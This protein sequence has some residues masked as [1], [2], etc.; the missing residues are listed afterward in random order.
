MNTNENSQNTVPVED[1]K[2]M[3]ANWR[4]FLETNGQKFNVRSYSIPLD[5]YQNLLTNNPDLES[6]RVYIG[7]KDENDPTSSTVF[8]VPI[9]NG[10]EKLYQD[11]KQSNVYDFVGACPPECDI[12]DGET[13]E[14]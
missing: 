10:Q 9:V 2:K 14:S 13:L 6:V 3:T 4:S 1:A 12:T 11:N 5:S 7:L 8:L